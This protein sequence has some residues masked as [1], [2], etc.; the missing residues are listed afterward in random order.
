MTDNVRFINL[1]RVG[2]T[3]TGAV[4]GATFNGP[5]GGKTGYS[6]N[7][8]GDFNGDGLSD[9]I[10]GSPGTTVGLNASSGQVNVFY[11]AK[12]TSAGFLSG[13]YNLANLPTSGATG[14][15][16]TGANAGDM[17][18]YAVGFTGIINSGQPNAILIGAPGFNSNAGTAYLI[19]GRANFTGTFSLSAAE[20]TTLQGNQYL[21]TSESTPPLAPNFFGASVSSRFQNGQQFT[22][23]GDSIADFII[24]APGY[25]VTGGTSRVEAGGAFIV[26]GG[27]ITVKIPTAGSISTTIG[28]GTATAPFSINAVTPAALQI[29]VFPNVSINPPFMPVD[30]QLTGTA[31]VVVNGVSYPNSPVVQDPDTANYIGGIPDYIVTISPRSSLNLAPGTTTF[32][33]D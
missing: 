27:L 30:I 20:G 10:L 7:T 23:D 5:T 3:G 2:A 13:T 8:A 16:L 11:G 25:N 29:F 17:A 28:V 6:V 15:V 1:N 21:L 26:Q 24:G 4:P 18:G 9:I 14:F 22:A 31:N 12:S 32:D 33:H 19:P